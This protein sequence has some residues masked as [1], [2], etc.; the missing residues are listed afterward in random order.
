MV[1]ESGL[2]ACSM[3]GG[4]GMRNGTRRG[5]NCLFLCVCVCVCVCDGDRGD[6]SAMSARRD[7]TATA[8]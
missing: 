8:P 4:K 6:A 1:G 2:P 5:A 7:R 3:Q